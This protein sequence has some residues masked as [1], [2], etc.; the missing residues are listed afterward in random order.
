MN[1]GEHFIYARILG[2]QIKGN[3]PAKD[4]LVEAFAYISVFTLCDVC[5]IKCTVTQ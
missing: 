5:R 4:I 2:K 1:F 3:G